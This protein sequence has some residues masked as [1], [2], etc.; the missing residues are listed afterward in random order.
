MQN[1]RS[2]ASGVATNAKK[3]TTSISCSATVRATPA[4]WTSA[5]TVCFP[6]PTA[7]MSAKRAFSSTETQG[8]V[9]TLFARRN[10]AMIAVSLESFS[11]T[12][13]AKVTIGTCGTSNATT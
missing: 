2:R 3:V 7:V 1:A 8:C 10:Y 9:K 13:V 12:G 5:M 6:A 4:S 11:V